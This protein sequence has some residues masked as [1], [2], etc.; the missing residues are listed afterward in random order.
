M[1]EGRSAMHVP[2][3]EEGVIAHLEPEPWAL[4]NRHLVR[5]AIAEFAH[6]RLI[7]P[8]RI[9]SLDGGDVFMLET[10]DRRVQY[11]FRARRMKLDHWHIE[12]AS[13]ERR[14]DGQSVPLDALAFITEFRSRLGIRE[15][16][17]P[18]YLDEISSILYAGTYKRVVRPH[19]AADLAFA[20]FQTIEAGMTEGHPVF[21]AN[22][23][24]LGFDAS[25]FAAYAPEA[26]APL[27]IVWLALRRS[28]ATFS[29]LAGLGHEELIREELGE[30]LFTAFC[31]RL[32]SL[33][34]NPADFHFLPV[35]PWQW[36][37]RI[38][39]GFGAEIAQRNIVFLGLSADRYRPQQAIRTLF[40]VSAPHKRYVKTALSILNMG[41]M[42][43]RGFSPEEMAA[44]PAIN[45]WLRDLLGRDDYLRRTGFSL[46]CEVATL[47]YRNT[48]HHAPQTAGFPQAHMLSALW[49]ESP[50]NGL[51][52]GE[53][54]MTMAALLHLDTKG[55]ALI[56][57]L[58]RASRL[59]AADW[60]R[61]YLRIYLVPVLH[62]FFAHDI[63]FMPHG[64]NVILVLDDNVPVRMI[65]KDLAEEMRILDDRPGLPP[66]VRRNRATLDDRVR[67]DGITTDVFDS[68]F[69][70][71]AAIL[72]DQGV[73]AEDVF[74]RLVGECVA[75]YQSTRPD[76]AEK[77]RRFDLFAPE[78]P[79]NCIN[80]L[81]LR[82]NQ[83]LLDPDNPDKGF[84]YAGTIRNPIADVR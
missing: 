28:H 80:R 67:L 12:T 10:E 30:E 3:P 15:A 34:L 71:L 76:L 19:R 14:R 20:E 31:R 60:I 8:A 53:R 42:L 17:L 39:I 26:A 29:S 1:K 66:A 81:Q 73:L 69:R 33:S 36:T 63:I 72:D 57:A 7:A 21:L 24:R 49:R 16:M 77:F 70:F 46:I 54:L 40:N 9:G 64:E 45:E 58:I 84:E 11:R 35:H 74:W 83:Q 61:R 52:S 27:K 18:V 78:F 4:M 2:I 41:F 62:C 50:V 51:R 5:K 59:Q 44:T 65:M 48:A 68:F 47:G 32:A 25:D 75:E 13:I 55:D 38:A 82:D 79:L 23:G 22:S 6:E 37:N 43:M 56:A